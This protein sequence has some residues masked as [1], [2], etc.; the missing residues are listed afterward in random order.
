MNPLWALPPCTCESS[1]LPPPRVPN[2]KLSHSISKKVCGHHVEGAVKWQVGHQAAGLEDSEE[3]FWAPWGWC[4]KILVNM[5]LR[6]A[7]EP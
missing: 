4:K 5:S 2:G 1:D 7:L 3:P 6:E